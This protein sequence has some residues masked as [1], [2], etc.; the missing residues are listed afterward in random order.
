MLLLSSAVLLASG[1]DV[2]TPWRQVPLFQRSSML[3]YHLVTVHV[4]W[5]APIH[6]WLLLASAWARRAAFLWAA[7]P[8]LAIGVVERIAFNTS[9]FAAM[10]QRRMA[11]PEMP[12]GNVR[13]D[14]LAH[15][16]P[17]TFLSAPGLWIGL[18]F[19]T[20]CLAAAVRLRR[21]REP[22]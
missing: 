17:G 2:A 4:F 18:A 3:L 22:I 14:P 13:M 7:L 21:K 1:L 10:L 8:P 6:A 5:Y 11:G 19:A 15:A 20:A 9:H 12:S 16:D